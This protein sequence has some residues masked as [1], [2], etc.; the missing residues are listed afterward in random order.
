[1]ITV[2]K[3]KVND[4]ELILYFEKKL[5]E[6]AN[7]IMN[8]Y[9]P[10]HN[11]DFSLK[12]NYEEIL[13]KYLKSM[14]Y[15]KNG[16]IFIAEYNGKPAGHIVLSIQ[17]SHPI[18]KLKYYGRINTIFIKKKFRGKGISSK[19]KNEAKKWFKR[20]KIKRVSLNV[21]PDNKNAI[22]VYKKWGLSISLLE[23]RMNL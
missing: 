5:I 14:I 8:K 3:A 17:K 2:R 9:C 19:L 23:M 13:S 18:F 7:E 4:I 1:M 16:S 15:S 12:S 21:F 22:N 6:S 20:K 11:I 10:Q